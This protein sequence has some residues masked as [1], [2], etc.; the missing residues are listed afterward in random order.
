[1]TKQEINKMVSDN[2]DKLKKA[3]GIRP[4]GTTE[5]INGEVDD[6]PHVFAIYIWAFRE[7]DSFAMISRGKNFYMLQNLSNFP[8]PVRL[9]L[10]G[11]KQAERAKI[12]AQRF[13]EI[14]GVNQSAVDKLS[15]D[16]SFV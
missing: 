4:L 8:V 14:V 16:I 1:M 3:F 9:K 15:K 6:I 5:F 7:F 13:N 10:K 11:R 2:C 12:V